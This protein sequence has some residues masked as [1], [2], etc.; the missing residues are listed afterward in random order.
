M[1][2]E[3]VR[4]SGFGSRAMTEEEVA[5]FLKRARYGVLSYTGDEGWPDSRIFDIGQYQGKYYFHSNKT[6]GEKLPFI[7]DGQKCCLCFF[8]PSTDIGKMRYCQHNSVLVYGHVERVDNREETH[9]E[10]MAGLR[11]MCLSSGTPFKAQPEKFEIFSKTCSV[12][13]VTPEYTVGKVVI[14]TS[15]PEMSYLEERHFRLMPK[16][17]Q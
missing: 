2:T 9:E 17:K 4:T 1:F 15:L 5:D 14:F 7:S 8:E 10:A 3:P 12:F 6:R 11:E 13:R 16:D